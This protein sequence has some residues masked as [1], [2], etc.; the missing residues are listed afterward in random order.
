MGLKQDIID[1]K[2]AAENVRRERI[3]LDKLK[4]EDIPEELKVESEGIRDAIINFLTHDDLHF[5]ISELKASLEIE[6]FKT[7]APL[8]AKVNTTVSSTVSAGIPLMAGIVAGATTSPGASKGTGTGV[9]SEP[10]KLRKDGAKHGGRLVATG[11]AYV[12]SDDPTPNSDTR[13][14]ENNFTKVK[15]YYDKIKKELL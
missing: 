2:V 13:D 10:I 9:V 6:E 14:E 12:G 11:H 7:Q 8:N 1:A 15:L 5:T 3:G 4:K